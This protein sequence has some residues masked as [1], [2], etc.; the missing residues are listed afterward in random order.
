MAEIAGDTE[1]IRTE[2]V[3]SM[4]APDAENEKGISALKTADRTVALSSLMQHESQLS[5][6]AEELLRLIGRT[7]SQE[8]DEQNI[9]EQL[10]LVRAYRS[11]VG[12]ERPTTR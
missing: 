7:Q 3:R 10:E 5:P 4:S 2:L 9:R 8:E 1:I 12:V 6:G 11:P